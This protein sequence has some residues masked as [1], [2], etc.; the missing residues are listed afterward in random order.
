MAKQEDKLRAYATTQPFQKDTVEIYAHDMGRIFAE[1]DMKVWQHA[2]PDLDPAVVQPI[3]LTDYAA[4]FKKEVRDSQDSTKFVTIRAHLVQENLSPPL[5]NYVLVH[6][7]GKSTK[8]RFGS[9]QQK[10]GRD[11]SRTQGAGYTGV[12]YVPPARKDSPNVTIREGKN[13]SMNYLLKKE[14]YRKPRE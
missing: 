10:Y 13:R 6:V 3:P 1:S 14:G 4:F 8:T 11:P 5:E 9:H 7:R 12:A 2:H